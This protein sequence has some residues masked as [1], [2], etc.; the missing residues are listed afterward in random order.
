M[1]RIYRA[2][3]PARESWLH[4]QR[5][6]YDEHR[7]RL[8]DL[9]ELRREETRHIITGLGQCP[10]CGSQCVGRK[11]KYVP[12]LRPQIALALTLFVFGF[13]C[14]FW[15]AWL[16]IP[17]CFFLFRKQVAVAN[18]GTCHFEWPA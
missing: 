17:L 3:R 13:F 15:V 18:C 5:R 10:N 16:F 14:F 8:S 12:D 4:R 6:I 7:Q 9:E 1:A 2:P 11:I